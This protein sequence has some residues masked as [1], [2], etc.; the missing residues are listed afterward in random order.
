VNENNRINGI[1]KIRYCQRSSTAARKQLYNAQAQARTY[2]YFLDFARVAGLLLGALPLLPALAIP[3]AGVVGAERGVER[4]LA[5]RL[6]GVRTLLCGYNLSCLYYC[7]YRRGQAVARVFIVVFRRRAGS[8]ATFV[9]RQ[10]VFSGIIFLWTT[11]EDKHH[12]L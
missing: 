12:M 11:Q 7:A 8:F 6:L 10:T 9:A 2:H 4:A 3:G 1:K 5:L